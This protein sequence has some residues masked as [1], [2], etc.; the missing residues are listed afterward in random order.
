M[1]LFYLLFIFFYAFF[2]WSMKRHWQ[3]ER[4]EVL[5]REGG[6]NTAI[7]IPFRNEAENL[8]GLLI[9]LENILSSSQAVVFIDDGSMDGSAILISSFIQERKQ[10]HWVLLENVGRGKKAALTTGI[11]Y[12]RAEIILTTD[13]DCNLP[14]QWVYHMTQ[15]FYNDEIQLVAG[16][17]ITAGGA[18]FFS[19]FQRIEWASLLLMTK[20]LF[21]K[22]RPLMCSGASLAYRKS[23]FLTVEGYVGNDMYPSGDDEFLLKKMVQKYGVNSMAYLQGPEVLVKT[24]PLSTWTAFF[25]QRIRWAGKW[26]LHGSVGPAFSGVLAFV[27]ALI[28]ISTVLLLFGPVESWFIFLVFWAVKVGIEKNVLGKVLADYQMSHS[29]SCFIRTSFIHPVYVILVGL[30]AVDGKYSWKGRNHHYK[31]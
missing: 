6:G 15:V 22:D 10:D 7:L 14:D 1:E 26:R 18:G 16:P 23:A 24:L 21:S 20:Y 3:K 8:P 2:L 17:V 27:L 28:E 5:Y 11:N 25:W 30:R 31:V 4:G 29:L 12:T 19:C 13:A 9:H